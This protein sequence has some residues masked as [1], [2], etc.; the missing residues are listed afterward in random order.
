MA[1]WL[2]HQGRYKILGQGFY[3]VEYIETYQDS[4]SCDFLQ[5]IC[6][7]I[8]KCSLWVIYI[9]DMSSVVDICSPYVTYMF[10]MYSMFTIF[11]ISFTHVHFI[12]PMFT[13]CH[14]R[15]P[16]D[17]HILLSYTIRLRYVQPMSSISIIY[18]WVIYGHHVT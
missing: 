11:H 12:S 17:L 10:Y 7:D 5:T 16:Y 13:R 1:Q 18:L 2:Y 9:E 3:Y 8:E 4:F 15:L 6:H 14:C